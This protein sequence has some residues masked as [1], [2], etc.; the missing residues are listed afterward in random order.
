MR[1]L[2]VYKR[3]LPYWSKVIS[4]AQS[5]IFKL[6]IL[7]TVIFH[8]VQAD[9]YCLVLIIYPLIAWEACYAGINKNV[10]LC[11]ISIKKKHINPLSMS[12]LCFG[13]SSKKII[14]YKKAVWFSIKIFNVRQIQ[15]IIDYSENFQVDEQFCFKTLPKHLTHLSGNSY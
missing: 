11:C 14:Q 13:S 10:T 5:Y 15:D 12:S 1:N 6:S 4:T 3:R 2:N 9:A 8:S 7:K